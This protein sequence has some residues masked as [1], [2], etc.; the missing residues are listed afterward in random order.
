MRKYICLFIALFMTASH[1]VNAQMQQQ[2]AIVKTHAR[3]RLDG[4]TSKCEYV[5]SAIVSIKNGA[6]VVS[7]NQGEL[8]FDVD[9]KSCYY[10]NSAYK[11]G[12]QVTDMSVLTNGHYY[13]G[14]E[15]L[16]I[17]MQN[18]V[19]LEKE[20]A[21]YKR[22]IRSHYQKE[23]NKRQDVID[24]LR[25][26]NLA[27]IEELRALQQEIDKAWEDAE[28]VISDMTERYLLVDFDYAT[29][30][31]K[32]IST[33]IINGKL[34]EAKREINPESVEEK[35]R[36]VKIAQIALD[37]ARDD[38]ARYC[39]HLVDIYTI[40]NKRDSVAHYLDLRASLDRTNIGWQIEAGRYITDL[41]CDYSRALSIYEPA[42]EYSL[43]H[44]GEMHNITATLY[45]NIGMVYKA[46]E[47]HTEALEYNIKAL[48]I[49]KKVCGEEHID[50]AK[51]YN[52]IGS[53]YKA[54][55][56]YLE[57]LEY[58]FKALEIQQKVCGEEHND[59]A[60]SYNNI[61]LVYKALGNYSEALTYLHKS[62]EIHKKIFGDEH[63]YI[64]ISLNNMGMVYKTL[65]DY[66]GAL[67]YLHKSLEIHEK[68]FGVEHI[69]AARMLTNIAGIYQT[70]GDNSQ[71]LEYFIKSETIFAKI[72]GEEH[73]ETVSLY[74]VIGLIYYTM[75]SYSEALEYLTK[76]EAAFSKIY[77]EDNKSLQNTRF[78][79]Q[80]IKNRL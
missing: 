13:S 22:V 50:T 9:T 56:N 6:Q 69:N 77:G 16:I 11:E 26:H 74:G 32:R 75:G 23:I 5:S 47:N 42:L 25:R 66:S 55:G 19:E 43:K 51:S 70:L 21:S 60:V 31:D 7:D 48:E 41:I 52:N 65:G 40:E 34:E 33:L 57:A 28:K 10:V 45:N 44:Y 54:L 3:Q 53:V 4:T 58:N 63:I 76:V 30:T 18:I 24:S 1:C 68:V 49:R 2:L 14:N 36:Q 72:Y 79:I 37:N 17:Y 38:A 71:A 78:F 27:T 20:R 12:Y 29:D 64:A 73:I 80:E 67:T 15:P 35:V 8:F 59:T 39:M 46:L 62:L 61:G